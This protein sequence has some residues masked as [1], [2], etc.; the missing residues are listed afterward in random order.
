LPWEEKRIAGSIPT[1]SAMGDGR[2]PL[3]HFLVGAI[4]A[5]IGAVAGSALALDGATGASAGGSAH[6][7]SITGATGN[8][9]GGGKENECCHDRKDFHGLKYDGLNYYQVTIG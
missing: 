4:H 2:G 3:L 6:V 8:E 9:G 7:M 5:T 1:S